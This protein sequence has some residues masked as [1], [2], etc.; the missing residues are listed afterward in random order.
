[1]SWICGVLGV[2]RSGFYEWLDR[3]PSKR[4]QNDQAILHVVKVSHVRSGGCYGVL[5]VWPDV[6]DSGYSVGRERVVRIMRSAGIQG[7][8]PKRRRPADKGDRPEH[9]IA[10]NV[11]DRNFDVAAPNKYWVADFTYV[12]TQEG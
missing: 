1:M 10:E 9:H 11:L 6:V 4:S 12:W 8:L 5:R 7:N 3:K 2:S